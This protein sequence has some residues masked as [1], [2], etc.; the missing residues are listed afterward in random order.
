MAAP[1]A[2][3]GKGRHIDYRRP[4]LYPAQQAAIFDGRDIQGQPARISTI[5]ASTKAGKTAA[6]IA[7]LIEQAILHTPSRGNVWWIAPVYGQAEIAYRRAKA[8]LPRW[9][10][11]SNE[12]K[13]T[14]TLAPTG[15]T[16]WF[17][18]GEKPD[19]L[20]GE[21]VYAAVIDEA[22]RV[23]EETWFA[24]RS[25]LTATRGPIRMIGNVKGSKNWF[26]KLARRAE[27]GEIG[28]SYAKLTAYDAIAGGVLASDE[29]EGARRDLPEQVFRELYLAEPS[30]DGSNPFGIQHI[31]R[32]MR[33]ALS[34]D[35]TFAAGVDLAKSIDWSV[36]IGL[37]RAAHMTGLDRWQSDWEATEKR[38]VNT[39]GTTDTLVD[40]TGVG[41][42]IVERIRKG[43][44]NISGFVFSST[45]KQQLME[46]LAVGIQHHEIGIVGDSVRAELETF[47]FVYTR[48]GVKYSAPD[49]YHDDQVCALALAYR[50]Y[51]NKRPLLD[52]AGPANND[53]VSPWFG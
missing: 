26:F 25:T 29:I 51:C 46:M 38:I 20:Y 34:E 48:T 19:N 27:A 23:R 16:L 21:D 45:T 53:R 3:A 42:P 52:V 8:G 22:S 44:P 36:I 6:C 37:D 31:A 49:G 28:Y 40:S 12:Q 18:S 2:H 10:Y 33:P 17:K 11:R 47:E 14:I 1:V 24:I 4:W 50:M 7:W 30:D 32:C 39:I 13:L 43:R 35:R 41:D 5:E 9:M 15:V